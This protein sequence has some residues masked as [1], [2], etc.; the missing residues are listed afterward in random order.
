MRPTSPTPAASATQGI[1]DRLRASVHGR[2]GLGGQADRPAPGGKTRQKP[3]CTS[4]HQG[5][6]LP[7]PESLAFR[8]AVPDRCG[9]CHGAMS[10]PY[11]LSMHGKL[12]DLGYG[13]AA[14]CADCHGSHDILPLDDPNSTLSPANRVQTC[15]KCHAN[16]RGQF[17][18]LQSAPR[19]L[20]TPRRTRWS[21]PSRSPC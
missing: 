18:Q 17:R 15:G 19:C 8:E 12:T 20:P 3:T 21:T 16:A 10:S 5:H 11:A 6:D 1:E 14:K 7:S 9:N 2:G 13:P 4:C